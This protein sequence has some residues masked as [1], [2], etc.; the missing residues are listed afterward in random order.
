MG[1]IGVVDDSGEGQSARRLDFPH[2]LQRLLRRAGQRAVRV[3][4]KGHAVIALLQNKRRIPPQG[5]SPPVIT[6]NIH[7][8]EEAFVL[9]QPVCLGGQGGQID[10][11]V[12]E[13]RRDQI[14]SSLR[15]F[16]RAVLGPEVGIDDIQIRDGRLLSLPRQQ[17][18]VVDGDVGLAGAVVSGK[19]R[20]TFMIHIMSFF[21]KSPL[22]HPGRS[23]VYHGRVCR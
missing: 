11:G 19:K 20:N 1:Q 13:L 7:N 3:G 12:G 9:H 4:H 16:R 22:T 6:A 17:K 8:G 10:I 15:Q 23:S 2:D 14:H 5:V 18:G 21:Q